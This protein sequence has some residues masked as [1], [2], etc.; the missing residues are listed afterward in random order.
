MSEKLKTGQFSADL[1]RNY[2]QLRDANAISVVTNTQ[3]VY[4]RAIEDFI[5]ELDQLEL[6][7]SDIMNSLTP[8]GIGNTAAVVSD[9]KAEEFMKKDFQLG[10]K[11]RELK[12]QLEIATDRYQKLFGPIKDQEDIK[13]HLPTWEAYE[14]EEE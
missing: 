10:Y 1:R 11:S 6:D 8:G 7:R 12:I 13:R 9:F 14:F 3:K 4:K 5:S 2:K